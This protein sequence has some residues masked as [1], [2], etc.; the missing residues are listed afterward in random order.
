[1]EKPVEKRT[2]QKWDNIKMDL[3]EVGWGSTD[4]IDIAQD[5]YGWW[6]LSNAVM[7]LRVP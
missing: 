6:S 3:Q 2:R 7:N 4:L 5:K 1:V